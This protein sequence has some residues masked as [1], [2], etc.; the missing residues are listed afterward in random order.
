MARRS[1]LTPAREERPTALEPLAVPEGEPA[2]ARAGGAARPSRQAKLH[3]GGYYDPNDPTIIAFQ[4]LGIDLRTP[5]Q[6]MLLE[7]ISDF[8]AKHQVAKAFR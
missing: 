4:K 1:L 3:I 2:R 8:V 6:A 7:A 5:Q